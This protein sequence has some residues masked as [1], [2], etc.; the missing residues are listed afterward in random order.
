MSNEVVIS[1]PVVHADGTMKVEVRLSP[2]FFYSVDAAA[3]RY[4][5]DREIDRTIGPG[6]AAQLKGRL[7][8]AFRGPREGATSV[9]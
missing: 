5:L 3:A 8:E 2:E 4:A 7:D 9:T 1:G 6:T